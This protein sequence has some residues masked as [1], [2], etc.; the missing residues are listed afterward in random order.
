MKRFTSR[1]VL[2]PQFRSP[3][4]PVCTLPGEILPPWRGISSTSTGEILPRF[5]IS[6]HDREGNP[7]TIGGEILPPE[8]GDSPTERGKFFHHDRRNTKPVKGFALCKQ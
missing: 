3:R 1:K 2:I 6:F 7:S 5:P 4:Q 8:R